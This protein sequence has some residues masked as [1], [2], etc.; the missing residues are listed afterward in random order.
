M[1]TDTDTTATSTSTTDA[2]K[3]KYIIAFKGVK[4]V[5]LQWPDVADYDA[6]F[7]TL[8]QHFPEIKPEYKDSYAIQTNDLDICGGIYV[9]IPRELWGNMGA[10]I[11]RIRIMD[12]RESF[13]VVVLLGL[14]FYQIL[15]NIEY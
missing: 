12:K 14:K 15:M 5:F 1:S 2:P 9:D 6:L 13:F 4:R 11:S 3:P 7:I 8:N 10:Q